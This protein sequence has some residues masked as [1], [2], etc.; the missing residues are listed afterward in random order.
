MIT[1]D[2]SRSET[3]IRYLVTIS[4][5]QKKEYIDRGM[6]DRVIRWLKMNVDHL[7]I[8]RSVYE[9]SGKYRQLHWHAIISVPKNFYYRPYTA[10]GDLSLNMNTYRVQYKKIY[11]INGAI[12]YIN[13][14]L[15]YKTQMDILQNN[16]Y[17][18]YRLDQK[19]PTY[20]L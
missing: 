15:Q 17:S 2:H 4:C 3:T 14:D 1:Q 12:K 5:Q 13:K 6:L 19:N 8:I 20:I 11:D 7:S 16:Y 9:N 18:K 10:Y